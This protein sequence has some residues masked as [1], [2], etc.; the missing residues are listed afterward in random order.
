[1]SESNSSFSSLNKNIKVNYHINKKYL[2]R[3]RQKEAK[4]KENLLLNNNNKKITSKSFMTE[5]KEEENKDF[6]TLEYNAI[7]NEI[8]KSYLNNEFLRIFNEFNSNPE[9]KINNNNH[10][11]NHLD[12]EL[13]DNDY[14]LLNDSNSNNKDLS[15][16][17]SVSSTSLKINDNNIKESTH[18]K[19][20]KSKKQER[21]ENKY[22]LKISDLK[23]MTNKPE[24]VELW[25]TTSKEPEYLIT[26]KSIKNTIPVPS[27]WLNKRKFLYSRKGIE[28]NTY[29]LPNNIKNTGISEL[30]DPDVID[31]RILKIKAKDKVNPKINKF[32]LDYNKLYEAFYKHQIKPQYLSKYGE[33]YY[34]GKEFNDKMSF[35]KPGRLSDRLKVALGMNDNIPGVSNAPPFLINFSR[36]GPPPAYPNLKIPGINCINVN[37]ATPNL[38]KAPDLHNVNN[39]KVKINYWGENKD[40]L[41]K[42]KY[43]NND[44]KIINTT[45]NRI[46]DINDHN[47]R[48]LLESTLNDN[49]EKNILNNDNNFI[50]K[51]FENNKSNLTATN[52]IQGKV[53]EKQNVTSIENKSL[54]PSSYKYNLINN[55]NIKNK[56]ENVKNSEIT[57]EINNNNDDVQK[58]VLDEINIKF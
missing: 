30:R 49:T 33:V 8:D 10:S 37:L 47:T 21:K 53:L 7:E 45:S 48:I 54:Y 2:K 6:K 25:D 19:P 17:S 36:Y 9:E 32:N 31:S 14:K 27:H 43:K 57:N 24:L 4:K 13:T 35:Y 52:K 40:N 18:K 41:N 29:V 26:I 5:N 44:D 50:S 28:T 46:N 16:N 12:D 1:M 11:N 22:K 51:Y 38:W 58:N 23:L 55:T 20:K 56:D 39:N 3:K 15:E 42:T 34:D